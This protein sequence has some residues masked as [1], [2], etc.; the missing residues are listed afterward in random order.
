[1]ELLAPVRNTECNLVRDDALSGHIDVSQS[2]VPFDFKAQG[3]VSASLPP[4]R[5]TAQSQ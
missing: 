4:L 3:Y 5:V 2:F 1:M